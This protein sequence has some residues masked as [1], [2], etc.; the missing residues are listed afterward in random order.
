MPEHDEVLPKILEQ[1]LARVLEFLKF[2]EAK[3]GALLAFSSAWIVAATNLLAR[4]TE[5]I[6]GLATAIVLSIPLFT[7][8]AAVAIWSFLPRRKLDIFLGDPNAPKNLLY[9]GHIALFDAS[10]Y[11]Q[12]V[13]EM[14]AASGG[15]GP[16]ALYL[17]DLF[18]Q[19][20]ANSRI[21]NAKFSLFNIGAMLAL[22]AV[23]ITVSPVV[24][25]A[26]KILLVPLLGLK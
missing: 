8:S 20:S 6:D 9:F 26:A 14:Y 4:K 2:A 11:R 17:D 23:I 13:R 7:A 24:Y 18:A 5:L 22:S 15:S 1:T 19:I 25:L 21:T 3:N 12:R 16:P 10:T